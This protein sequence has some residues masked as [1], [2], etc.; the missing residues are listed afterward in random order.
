MWFSFVLIITV[1]NCR[2][3][4]TN[5]TSMEFVNN[6][7]SKDITNTTNFVTGIIAFKLNVYKIKLK[8][9]FQFQ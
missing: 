6:Q 2:S 8:K 4:E 3:N 1:I 7:V 9:L 5:A